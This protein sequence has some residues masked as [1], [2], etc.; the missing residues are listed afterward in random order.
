MA[1]TAIQANGSNV[2]IRD[3]GIVTI[4]DEDVAAI[5]VIG[6]FQNVKI[7]NV[8]L[9]SSGAILMTGGDGSEIVGCDSRFPRGAGIVVDGPTGP[10]TIAQNRVEGSSINAANPTAAIVIDGDGSGDD[11]ELILVDNFASSTFG[12]GMS[13]TDVAGA[14]I[15]GNRLRGSSHGLELDNVR[16]ST[17]TD[18]DID[19]YP[20]LAGP[21]L[22]WHG[23][24]MND[25]VDSTVANNKVANPGQETADT[26][27]GIHLSGNTDRNLIVG[28]RVIPEPAS[29]RYGINVSAATCDAN[30]INGNHLGA[31]ADYASGAFND[32]GTGTVTAVGASGQFTT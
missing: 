23:I 14:V 26:Y 4:G 30:V 20:G 13:V 6:A 16:S 29:T 21:Y 32:A 10:L 24:V 27:D 31:A 7:R 5:S 25:V 2:T 9:S 15:D 3:V 12:P 11:L 22:S 8:R 1:L 19:G 18:N 28:N 17:I